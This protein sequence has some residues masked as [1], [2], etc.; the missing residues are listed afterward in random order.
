[1]VCRRFPSKNK[2]LWHIL[3]RV[4]HL[5]AHCCL[6]FLTSPSTKHKQKTRH[7]TTSRTADDLF[8]TV[9]WC[10]CFSHPPSLLHSSLYLQISA[11]VRVSQ[12]RSGGWV[13]DT[14]VNTFSL[15]VFVFVTWCQT[16]RSPDRAAAEWRLSQGHWGSNVKLSKRFHFARLF[17]ESDVPLSKEVTGLAFSL[18]LT[19]L[20][21]SV[22][23]KVLNR[24]KKGEARPET[25]YLHVII[26]VFV[27]STV[28]EFL[29]GDQSFSDKN[30]LWSNCWISRGHIHL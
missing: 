14:L 30:D 28:V 12:S 19:P 9:R 16:A 20:E 6:C 25:L 24:R 29:C 8:G 10:W 18:Q 4:Q 27:F 13:N 23:N 21:Y 17:L 26:S 11:R 1:M 2:F 3:V 7:F 15:S 5:S 22:K